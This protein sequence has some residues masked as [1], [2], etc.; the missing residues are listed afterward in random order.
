MRANVLEALREVGID[1]S[2]HVPRKL[3]E[4]AI[5]RADAIVAI[6]AAGEA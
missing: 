4:D 5:D 2:D 1:A 3:D 6:P